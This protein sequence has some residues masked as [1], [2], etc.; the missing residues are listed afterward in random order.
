MRS[1]QVEV[2]HE[3]LTHFEDGNGCVDVASK[4]ALA[5]QVGKCAEVQNVR[6]GEKNGVDFVHVIGQRGN[7]V[8]VKGAIPSAID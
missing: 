3:H 1:D 8:F 2:V 6:I 7:S 5:Y 4:S